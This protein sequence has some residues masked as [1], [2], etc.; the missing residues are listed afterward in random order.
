MLRA[1]RKMRHP[2]LVEVGLSHRQVAPSRARADGDYQ[3]AHGLW[4]D[5]TKSCPARAAPAANVPVAGRAQPQ[6]FALPQSVSL[7]SSPAT[8]S[9]VT[10]STPV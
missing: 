10:S 2:G 7:E 1:D 3:R 5:R 6:Q 8:A 9:L 4:S